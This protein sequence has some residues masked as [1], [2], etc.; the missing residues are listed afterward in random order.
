MSNI[1]SNNVSVVESNGHPT[2]D[3]ADQINI[4]VLD[5]RSAPERVMDMPELVSHILQFVPIVGLRACGQINHLWRAHVDNIWLPYRDYQTTSQKQFESGPRRIYILSYFVLQYGPSVHSMSNNARS[6]QFVFSCQAR[7]GSIDSYGS[8]GSE[9]RRR[10]SGSGSGNSGGDGGFHSHLQRHHTHQPGHDLEPL[11]SFHTYQSSAIVPNVYFKT[12]IHPPP[13][14]PLSPPPSLPPMYT[15]AQQHTL[16]GQIQQQQSPTIDQLLDHSNA[17]A[18]DSTQHSYDADINTDTTT[19]IMLDVSDMSLSPPQFP[20]GHESFPAQ[21]SVS[22]GLASDS[23]A[24]GRSPVLRVV[25][26]PYEHPSD[27]SMSYEDSSSPSLIKKNSRASSR[28]ENSETKGSSSSSAGHREQAYLQGLNMV[29]TMVSASSSTA[30]A[31]PFL[32]PASS[33]LSSSSSSSSYTTGV[34]SSFAYSQYGGSSSTSRPYLESTRSGPGNEQAGEYP[35]QRQLHHQQFLHPT[36]SLIDPSRDSM[37][38]DTTSGGDTSDTQQ[39]LGGS[40]TTDV[41]RRHIA[42]SSSSSSIRRTSTSSNNSSMVRR[43]HQHQHHH[44]QHQQRPSR[45]WSMAVQTFYYLRAATN[46]MIVACKEHM[47]SREGQGAHIVEK[48]ETSR[49]IWNEATRQEHIWTITPT[50]MDRTNPGEFIERDYD[51]DTDIDVD[52]DVDVETQ[53]ILEDDTHGGQE[54][55]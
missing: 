49:I 41:H 55:R 52:V 27:G 3:N 37:L 8:I 30:T 13:S 19:S 29:N 31:L 6:Y 14:H 28:S 39:A 33:S 47:H 43:Q 4:A 42:Q 20:Y 54:S 44:L 50:L 10:G 26:C 18:S 24:A 46:A 2:M 11:H 53:Q 22:S 17:Q 7:S 51:A 48:T 21:G 38:L 5:E 45:N 35:Q 36:D 1:T 34:S 40:G 15:S 9:R 12:G 32:D 16:Q 25:P 23:S